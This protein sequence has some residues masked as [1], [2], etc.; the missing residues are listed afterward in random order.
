MSH[1]CSSL[2]IRLILEFITN[3]LPTFIK[4][5]TLFNLYGNELNP[6]KIV[7]LPLIKPPKSELESIIVQIDDG[8]VVVIF[9]RKLAY[10]VKLKSLTP[11]LGANTKFPIVKI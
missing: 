8:N 1:I 4:C 7:Y 9:S 5:A 10:L 11:I 2:T 3:S 6:L